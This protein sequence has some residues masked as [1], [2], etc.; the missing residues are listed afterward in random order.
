MNGTFREIQP[1]RVAPGSEVR[2][3][4]NR[5]VSFKESQH[6]IGCML[7]QGHS[8]G[9]TFSDRAGTFEVPGGPCVC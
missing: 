3:W 6:V 4:W 8:E 1:L 9:L 5:K 7:N 2:N